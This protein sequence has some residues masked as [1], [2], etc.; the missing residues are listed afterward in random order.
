MKK[1]SFGLVSLLMAFCMFSCGSGNTGQGLQGMKNPPKHVIL[2]GFDGLSAY[3]LNHGPEM[4][5]FRK[6]VADGSSTFK[7]RSVLPS[8][9]AV[10]WASMF[11]GAGPELHGYTTWNTRIPDLP[12]RVLTENN[13]F[14]DLYYTI[15]KTHP[16]A[17]LGFIYE[18]KGMRYVVDTLSI[19]Y[20]QNVELS[21]E[22]TKEAL[23][24]TL[25]YITTKKPAFCS[26]VFA[27]PDNA[28]H[29]YGWDSPEYTAQMEHVDVALG[30]IVK[31]VKDAGMFDETVF[32]LSADHGGMDKKHGGKTMKEMQTA[33]VFSGK[34]I[35]KGFTIPESTMVYDIAGTIGY[36]FGIEQPQ[37]WI[38]RPIKSIFVE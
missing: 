33:V 32:V 15:H 34:G 4:P 6:L 5:N 13:M 38:A 10:N 26:V 16:K 23:A 8:S 36:I 9:S 11:M 7:N 31:A 18:W 3:R 21:G 12:S 17:E 30:E 29:K 14:P 37:V 20:I 35:K 1:N 2:V 24:S 25:N 27:Q 22:N 28:G 19:N